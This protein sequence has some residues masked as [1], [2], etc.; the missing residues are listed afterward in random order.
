MAAKT[1]DKM[2]SRLMEYYPGEEDPK[3]VLLKA[4]DGHHLEAVIPKLIGKGASMI[5][6]ATAPAPKKRAGLIIPNK[7][8]GE[9]EFQGKCGLVLRMGPSAYKYVGSFEYEDEKP[10]I[11]DWVF[12]RAAE[13]WACN[14][15]GVPCRWVRDESVV[16]VINDIEA[17]Y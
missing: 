15:N 4:L 9:I 10:E 3:E 12:Y 16:G 6:V 2:A 8:S 7:T 11:G 5:L 14:I 1:W 13:T 17:I